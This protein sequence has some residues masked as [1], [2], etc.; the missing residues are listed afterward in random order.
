MNRLIL[1][2]TIIGII[3]V[4]GLSVAIYS[5]NLNHS[6]T[7]AGEINSATTWVPSNS[8]YN[9]TA[10]VTIIRGAQL[11][12][13]PG[14]VVNFNDCAIQ[15]DGTL[16]TRGS[17]NA[18]ITFNGGQIIFSPSSEDWN[19][20]TSSGSIIQRAVFNKCEV[21]INSASPK[22]DSNLFSDAWE[23]PNQITINGG[24]PIIS[25]N[26]MTNNAHEYMYG[27]IGGTGIKIK[28]AENVTIIGNT[29]GDA[30][31]GIFVDPV[32]EGFTFSSLSGTIII[33][34]NIIK[35]N[36]QSGI[37]LGAPITLTIKGNTITENYIGIDVG[38]FSD[39][40]V[41][42]N[43][44]IYDNTNMSIRIK[45]SSWSTDVNATNNWWGTTDTA[46]ISQLIH[47]SQDDA[48]LGTVTF[49]PILQARNI[50][51]DSPP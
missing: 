9:L 41:L 27:Y 43:N 5:L 15:V 24:S 37:S 11:T 28:N 2:L 33:E 10:N 45:P 49:N 4:A 6:I 31:A 19:G 26:V 42:T 12:I 23:G 8:P 21:R 13:E 36:H 44:N 50:D 35:N 51:G 39:N 17:S 22:V 16:C 34:N 14:V 29:I 47:D 1:C 46:A 20:Q 7:F 40:S 3:T 30:M 32:I 18:N 38:A 48:S 25:N